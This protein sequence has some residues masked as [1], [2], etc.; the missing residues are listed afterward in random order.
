V[1]TFVLRV[2]LPDRP[3]ALGAVASRIGSVRGD[4]VAVEIVE[5]GDGRAVDEFVVEV[6]DDENLPLLLSEIMEVDGVEVEEAHPIASGL[7][8]RRLDAYDTAALIVAE[9][10]PHDV[11]RALATRARHELD[12]L[13]ATVVDVSESMLVASDGPTPAAPWIA[14]F[15]ESQRRGEPG[16]DD[17]RDLEWVEL[18]TWD[19]VLVVGRPG[20]RF[21]TR[22]RDRMAA[23]ARLADARWIDVSERESKLPRSSPESQT[24]FTSSEKATIRPSGTPAS[25]HPAETG[26][27]GPTLSVLRSPTEP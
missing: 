18:A 8:D 15:V 5:R 10:T 23:L 25:M 9:R 19:L 17:Q 24:S 4:V 1:P 2:G 13:W 22:E 14:E 27:E 6:E 21:G 7:R 26:R 3:G 11:V 16:G 12:A 20:W